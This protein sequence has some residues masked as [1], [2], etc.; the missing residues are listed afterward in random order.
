MTP[1]LTAPTRPGPDT[2]A[3]GSTRPPAPTIK[4]IGDQPRNTDI[5]LSGQ[6]THERRHDLF[7]ALGTGRPWTLDVTATEGFMQAT[8]RR[9]PGPA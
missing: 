1:A 4:A 7:R 6:D 2:S 8:R 3:K 5:Y 9:V